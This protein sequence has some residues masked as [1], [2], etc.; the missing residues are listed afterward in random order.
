MAS[1]LPRPAARSRPTDGRPEG[2][3]EVPMGQLADA[4][5]EHR[6]RRG[7]PTDSRAN[8]LP[9]VPVIRGQLPGNVTRLHAREY[10]SG[11][12]VLDGI[13]GR[14]LGALRGNCR[15]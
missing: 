14:R 15:G 13:Q 7:Q 8:L 6:I 9:F 2:H 10:G 1:D 4:R 12:L 11:N 5:L 3:D